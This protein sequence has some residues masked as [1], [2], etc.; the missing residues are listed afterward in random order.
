MPRLSICRNGPRT[1]KRPKKHEREGEER[2]ERPDEINWHF[3][4]SCRFVV[5]LVESPDG[6]TASSCV[7]YPRS[8]ACSLPGALA[9]GVEA[10]LARSDRQTCAP[11]SFRR[12]EIDPQ[13]Y[14][15]QCF[16]IAHRMPDFA[17]FE[18]S[19]ELREW[20]AFTREP[21]SASPASHP[22]VT[23]S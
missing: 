14:V 21:K 10:R 17:V 5:F 22:Y 19:R 3:L 8:M 2:V 15:G 11:G 13:V 20:R 6:P 7:N 9:N 1:T 16:A 12:D 23:T 4:L 18:R